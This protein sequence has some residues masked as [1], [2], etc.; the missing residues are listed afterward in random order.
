ML[1][2]YWSGVQVGGN[3]ALRFVHPIPQSFD[4]WQF[5]RQKSRGDGENRRDIRAFLPYTQSQRF[6]CDSIALR[7][8]GWN[9]RKEFEA[10]KASLLYWTSNC[11][12]SMQAPVWLERFIPRN[13]SKLTCIFPS[14]I[15]WF[16]RLS[17][18]GKSHGSSMMDDNEWCPLCIRNHFRLRRSHKC[19]INNVQQHPQNAPR[20]W[21]GW[22]LTPVSR[23]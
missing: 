12:R 8:I 21:N 18:P 22:P 10:F 4:L 6:N 2:S 11:L 16:S 17:S 23:L 20:I 1:L 14:S 9:C 5:L 7:F 13:S 19:T 15:S 3:E